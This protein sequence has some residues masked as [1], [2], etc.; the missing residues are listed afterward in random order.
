[1]A[2]E[3]KDL[4]KVMLQ[5]EEMLHSA[6]SLLNN[7]EVLHKR[8]SEVSQWLGEYDHFIMHDYQLFFRKHRA[9]L[10]FGEEAGR[11]IREEALRYEQ[12]LQEEVRA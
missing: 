7:L 1:M 9:G 5:A 12:A 3:L 4:Q 8:G 10:V 11:L 6:F 2:D